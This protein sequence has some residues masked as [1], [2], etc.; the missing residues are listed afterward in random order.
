[1]EFLRNEKGRSSDK[2]AFSLLASFLASPSYALLATQGILLKCC[3]FAF[4]PVP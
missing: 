4:C 1:M 3:S 2:N